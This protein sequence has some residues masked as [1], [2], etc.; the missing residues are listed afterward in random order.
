MLQ[1]PLRNIVRLQPATRAQHTAARNSHS[2]Q[3]SEPESAYMLPT[4]N[5]DETRYIVTL[6]TNAELHDKV[7]LMRKRYFPKHLNK[8][9]AHLT[10]F[11]ALPESRLES[12]VVPLLESF[13]SKTAQFPIIAGPPFAMNKGIGI[14]VPRQKGG[15]EA[16][17]VH[18]ALL[19]VWSEG[20]FL[21]SQDARHSGVHYTIMN[22]VDDPK[23]VSKALQQVK[24]EWTETVG[25]A[26][27]LALWQYDRGYWRSERLFPFEGRS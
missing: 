23:E 19:K 13:T 1:R 8:L 17:N 20:G 2:H 5:N 27:G 26:V 6:Y 7:T 25:T 10:L 24:S 11:H 9:S 15:Q 18:E 21:T 4:E 16:R 12:D 22:K 3:H 14:S